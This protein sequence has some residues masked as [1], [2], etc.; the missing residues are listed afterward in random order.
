M[1][2]T[3]LVVT[4]VS[5]LY[6]GLNG[7]GDLAGWFGLLCRASPVGQRADNRCHLKLCAPTT[8]RRDCARPAPAPHTTA[9]Q[10]R[11]RRVPAGWARRSGRRSARRPRRA[12]RW[13]AT[14]AVKQVATDVLGS[15][16]VL[17]KLAQ[18]ALDHVK[19]PHL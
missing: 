14:A 6:V 15:V 18:Q 8:T 13:A 5:H 19:I 11:S 4:D 1:T 17:G 16:P 2:A 7:R 10:D 3:G 9:C 12:N